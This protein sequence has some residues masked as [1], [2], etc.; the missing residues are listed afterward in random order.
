MSSLGVSLLKIGVCLPTLSVQVVG[1]PQAELAHRRIQ[2]H[3]EHIAP[4][5]ALVLPPTV[6]DAVMQHQNRPRFTDHRNL[7]DDILITG[8]VH[9]IDAPVLAAGNQQRPAHFQRHIMREIHQL[10]VEVH[11]HINRRIAVHML[12]RI[13]IGFAH[14]DGLMVEQRVRPNQAVNDAF[15]LRR[16]QNFTQRRRRGITLGK[17][18]ARR[19]RWNTRINFRMAV[20]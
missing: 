4:F 8:N 14:M 2:T 10:N 15:D 3:L 16:T 9:L 18:C 12:R 1:V 17:G 7:P 13:L 19:S 5:V 20:R 6:P 11:P